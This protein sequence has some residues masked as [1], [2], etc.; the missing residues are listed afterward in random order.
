VPFTKE[1]SV[2]QKPSIGRIVHYQTKGTA[3][4]SIPSEVTAAMITKIH[5]GGTVDLC[6]FYSN[7][8]SFKTGLP[9]SLEPLSGAWNWPPRV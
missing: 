1:K 2:D 9:F 3:D 4:G 5:E 7:G 8:H 6:V